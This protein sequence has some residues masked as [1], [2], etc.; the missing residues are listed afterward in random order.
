MG[1]E[2]ICLDEI[3][4]EYSRWRKDVQVLLQGGAGECFIVEDEIK[5]IYY[6]STYISLQSIGDYRV[7][8]S[9][10][11][12]SGNFPDSGV[13]VEWSKGMISRLFEEYV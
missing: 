6:D 2:E 3:K 9:G 12:A 4:E 13:N 1:L 5:E 11:S 8:G 10:N 7:V